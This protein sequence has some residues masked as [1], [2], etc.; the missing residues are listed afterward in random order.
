MSKPI[1]S[2]EIL[3]VEDNPDDVMLIKEALEE[4]NI[5]NHIIHLQDGAD[6]MDYLFHEGVYAEKE[7]DNNPKIIMLDI[8]MP[9]MGGIELLKKLKANEKT[10][11]I[12]VVVFTSSKDDPNL[13]ECYRLGVNNYMIKP[14]DYTQFK[15]S[16][17][18]SIKDLLLYFS[19]FR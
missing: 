13:K 10:K 9:R 19:M 5:L 6:A 2:I 4:N 18:K 14:I 3:L 16:I 12:P 17:N 11:T 7:E 15:L 8:N 1:E